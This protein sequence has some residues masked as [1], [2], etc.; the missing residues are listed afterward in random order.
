MSFKSR[1]I[2]KLCM[3]TLKNDPESISNN[4]KITPESFR[5]NFHI[6]FSLPDPKTIDFQLKSNKQ[7]KSMPKICQD[8]FRHPKYSSISSDTQ[9]ISSDTQSTAVYIQTLK[10]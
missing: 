10:V 9:S 1:N 5:S 7:F 4:F 6:I 3:F 2:F 8:K